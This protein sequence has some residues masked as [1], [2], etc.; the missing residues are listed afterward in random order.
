MVKNLVLK[1]LLASCFLGAAASLSADNPK[2]PRPPIYDENADGTKQ[3]ADALATAQKDHK[4]VLLMFG[5][6][7]C[8]W[9]HKLHHLFDTDQAVNETL[10]TNFV[11]VLIDVNKGHNKEVDGKYGHPIQHGLPVLV[12]LEPD[13]KQLTTKDTGELEEADHHSPQK[14]LEFLKTWAPK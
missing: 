7:W 6:N 10:K 9:C 14:V 13:G 12:V 11:I 8:G 1:I 3:V 5:A 4:R 2:P